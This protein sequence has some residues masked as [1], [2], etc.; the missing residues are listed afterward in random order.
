MKTIQ[1]R[2]WAKVS[3]G[4]K[5]DCWLWTAALHRNGYGAFGTAKKP[6]LAHRYSFELHNG[7]I[8]NGM[9]IDHKCHNRACVNPGHLQ[10][11]THKQNQENRD[12]VS[13]GT[14]TG[15]RGVSFR[16]DVGKFVAR[17]VHNKKYIHIGYFNTLPE[18]DAAAAAK[19][20]ELFTNSIMDA[21][22]A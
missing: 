7:I 14:T 21:G 22:V 15:I 16:K 19:R 11:V 6:M 17:I 13:R 1:D 8:P 18:A 2:F 4:G 10:A 5:S 3:V 20:D 12:R 9:Q